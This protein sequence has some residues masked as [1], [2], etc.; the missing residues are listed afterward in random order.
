[1]FI[2]AG[3]NIY[4]ALKLPPATWA[5]VMS[6][7]GLVTKFGKF[8]KAVDPGLVKVNPLSE[9]LLQVDVKIQI[10]GMYLRNV[11]PGPIACFAQHV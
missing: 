5:G 10:V 1:M 3:V 11:V 4:L 7:Y 9:R 2:S 8:Y 6:T